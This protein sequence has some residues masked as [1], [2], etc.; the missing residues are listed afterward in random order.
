MK[1]FQTALLTSLTAGALGFAL[2][3][4]HVKRVDVRG[5]ATVNLATPLGTPQHRAAGFLY[6]IPIAQDQ[7][8]D[9]FYTEMGFNYGRAGG[10]SEPAPA[11]G[12]AYGSS[13]FTV[14]FDLEFPKMRFLYDYLLEPICFFHFILQDSPEVWCTHAAP[15][16]RSLGSRRHFK[17]RYARRQWGL[18][19]IQRVL[20]RAYQRYQR[21]RHV[22]IP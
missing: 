6:G 11:R 9:H 14:G 21:Q 3:P 19:V 12:W 2:E 4:D 7:I 15:H 8:P 22:A 20:E 16:C 10:G 18:V 5:T 1:L 17:N 13:E